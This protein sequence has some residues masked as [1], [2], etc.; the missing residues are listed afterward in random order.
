MVT[1]RQ[2]SNSNQPQRK[3]ASKGVVK[4]SEGAAKRTVK[5]KSKRDKGEFQKGEF[6]AEQPLRLKKAAPKTRKQSVDDREAGSPRPPRRRH[7]EERSPA[8]RNAD[9]RSIDS[10]RS[11]TQSSR[12][13]RQPNARSAHFTPKQQFRTSIP[14][15]QA[16]LRDF[17]EVEAQVNSDTE[18]GADLIYGRHSVLAAL[19][20][21]RYLNRIWI[22]PRLRYDPRFH[23]LLLQAKASGAVIDEADQ[24]RLDQIT[25]GA[26][27]Q[28]IAA[29]VAPY[30]YL[31]L[32]DLIGR[33]KATTDQPVL[34]VADGITDP[35]NLGAIIRTAEAIGAQGLVIP[36]RRAV[37]VTSTVVK[38]AAGALE[39]FPVARVVNLGRALEELKE[40]GF[41]IYGTAATASQPADTVQFSGPTVLVIGSEGEGLNLLTQRCCDVLISI[42]LQGNTPSL[43]ASVA[44]GMVLYE[45]FRQRR[46][47]T[48]NLKSVSKSALQ[49]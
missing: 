27:H 11:R 1:K 38:V 4:R 14:E 28:G 15:A 30:E 31:D 10:R 46:S 45:V 9:S 2:H 13:S 7:Q 47:H 20:G 35:H 22:M 16:E 49:S 34:I 48:F 3:S 23:S 6:Q 24:R 5:F 43:N 36:Q 42:P 33:A 41:W 18:T 26:N 29:Q 44:A 32:A 19:E 21:Q 25:Q 12:P 37:G 40:A 17:H 8:S 39:T